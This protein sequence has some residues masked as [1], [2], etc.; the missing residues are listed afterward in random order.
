M[1]TLFVTKTRFKPVFMRVVW[2]PVKYT[3]GHFATREGATL[4]R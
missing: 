2:I 1:F 3:S 4:I